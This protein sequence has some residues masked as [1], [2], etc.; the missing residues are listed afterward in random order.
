MHF[1]F[2]FHRAHGSKRIVDIIER[3][4]ENVYLMI[5]PTASAE[6]F[7][8]V[9][10]SPRHIFR[11]EFFPF[12]RSLFRGE[13]GVSVD[14]ML[15]LVDGNAERNE[16]DCFLQVL[17]AE[18]IRFV[19][20]EFFGVRICELLHA[21]GVNFG[22]VGGLGI[23]VGDRL[24]THGFVTRESVSEFVRKHLNISDRSVKAREHERGFVFKNRGHIARRSLT[25]LIL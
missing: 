23:I 18:F 6:K 2:E 10:I 8:T 5:P 3:I 16:S 7:H 11:F 19:A 21:H 4:E 20:E 9:V 22:Y 1:L 14:D 15:I 25:R 13:F 17:E 12:R 24:I